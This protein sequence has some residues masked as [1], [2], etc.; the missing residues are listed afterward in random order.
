MLD[1]GE[2][3]QAVSLSNNQQYAAYAC[4]TH[5]QT[6]KLSP[7]AITASQSYQIASESGTATF[8]MTDVAWNQYDIEKIAA[9]ATN[10]AIVV[11][12]TSGKFRQS[13]NNEWDSGQAARAVS[14]VSWHHTDKYSLVSAHQDGNV[15]LWDTARQ[16]NCC[17]KIFNAHADACRDAKFSPHHP[18]ILASIY[19]NG[20][21]AVWDRRFPNHYLCRIAAH[22][23]SG[24]A[25]AWN[26]SV[27]WLVATGSRDKTIKVWDLTGV[28]EGAEGAG[29]GTGCIQAVSRPIHVLHTA[30]TVGRIAWRPSVS[31]TSGRHRHTQLAAI[32]TAERGDIS[33]WDIGMPN[34][35]A[36]LLRGHSDG[37][38]GLAWLDTPLPVGP[39][40]LIPENRRRTGSNATS[41]GG[42]RRRN[43]QDSQQEDGPTGNA[44]LS[45]LYQHILS[46]GKDGKLLVQ[47]VRNAHFPG[48]HMSKHVVAVSALGHCAYQRGQLH[49][50]DPLGLVANSQT[51]SAPGWFA[52]DP[53][54]FG[55]PLPSVDYPESTRSSVSVS[56]DPPSL[57]HSAEIDSIV[58]MPGHMKIG[59]AA[60]ESAASSIANITEKQF[61][62]G[63]ITVGMA[64][65]DSY[66]K[67]PD[68]LMGC[69][70]EGGAFDPTVIKALAQ[71][72]IH[73][74]KTLI[75]PGQMPEAAP[76]ISRVKPASVRISDDYLDGAVSPA[77]QLSSDDLYGQP[78]DF[79]VEDGLDGRVRCAVDACKWNSAVA[80]KMGLAG[81]AALWAAMMTLVPSVVAVVSRAK[82][83]ECPTRQNSSDLV[84]QKGSDASPR[85]QG[86]GMDSLGRNGRQD[87]TDYLSPSGSLWQLLFAEETMRDLLV[88]LVDCGDCQHFVTCCEIFREIDG[89]DLLKRITANIGELR[90]REGYV[91]YLEML[92]RLELFSCANA[93]IV[94]SKDAHISRLSQQGVI[95]RSACAICGK[96]LNP[97]NVASH[98]SSSWCQKCKRCTGLC[99]L[100][101]QPVR[102][103]F[104]WCPVCGHG[105]HISCTTAWFENN[106]FCPS[107][108]GH[109][110]V[111]KC[112]KKN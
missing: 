50:G 30:S 88:E 29:T 94:K 87:D 111:I 9:T 5:I 108:C 77:K 3:L 27:E 53:S 22:S 28:E 46:V 64:Y 6:C 54:L 59:P 7:T 66:I 45:G 39:R 82:R 56:K 79:D 85:R 107:G 103:M 15:M 8:K 24:L 44:S 26:P 52:D 43:S 19:E 49:R 18:H 100:C 42:T 99:V 12:N 58:E 104:H 13:G 51:A 60:S 74:N 95:I 35:P 110:C 23:E 76:H 14:R 40:S 25:V 11:F 34:M 55:I 84:E 83:L 36:C 90:V 102:G 33:V 41:I 71:G 80:G 91:A 73:S 72:Y 96:E 101:Q 47:D 75:C 62:T 4:R 92:N 48:Q 1:V 20:N 37:C 93:I 63:V 86:S 98:S 70:A 97:E 65:L 68:A 38:M 89:G 106:V 31:T 16:A 81:H 105:G 61:Q 69:G 2:P 112:I 17:M 21:L 78:H 67:S 109:K 57:T 10:G 32:S